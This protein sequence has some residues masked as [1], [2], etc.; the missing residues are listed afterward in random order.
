MPSVEVV[1]LFAV[2]PEGV[3]VLQ[4]VRC[5]ADQVEILVFL[6]RVFRDAVAKR[7][8]PQCGSVWVDRDVMHA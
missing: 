8:V 3:Y 6:N 5:E 4:K 7:S 1:E 2:L